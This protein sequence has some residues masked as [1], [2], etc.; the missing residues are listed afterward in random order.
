[1]ITLKKKYP[2]NLLWKK[3][4]PK[5]RFSFAKKGSKS[6]KKVFFEKKKNLPACLYRYGYD[7]LNIV[8]NFFRNKW[9]SRYLSFSGF[10]VPKNCSLQ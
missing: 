9:V 1:M 10:K 7:F 4:G 3:I 6:L 5:Q 2:I 8:H